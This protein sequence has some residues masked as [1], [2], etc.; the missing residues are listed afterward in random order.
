MIENIVYY[1][2]R[3]QDRTHFAT[4]QWGVHSESLGSAW[5]RFGR[6]NGKCLCSVP[7]E[8]QAG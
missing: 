7:A 1:M 6:Y 3:S 8:G 2:H 4:G 5:W